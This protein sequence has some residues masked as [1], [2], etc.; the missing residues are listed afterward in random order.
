MN[1]VVGWIGTLGSCAGSV[2]STLGRVAGGEM[3]GVG[4]SSCRCES[5]GSATL[6]MEAKFCKA[7]CWSFPNSKNGDAGEGFFKVWIKSSAAC[8]AL[9]KAD[10]AG[11]RKR[12]GKKAMVSAIR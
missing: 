5:V 7:F 1:V 4:I 6:K 9:S 3:I 11:I 8:V 12:D 10:D 2:G